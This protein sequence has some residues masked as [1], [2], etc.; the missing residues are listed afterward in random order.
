[1]SII[2]PNI[3]NG[4]RASRMCFRQI[5]ILY[6]CVSSLNALSMPVFFSEIHYDNLGSDVGEGFEVTGA[7]GTNLDGWSVALVNGSNGETYRNITLSG[8]IDNESNNA[9]A[10]GFLLG[11]IQNSV[12]GLALFNSF[13][14]L[15][16]FISYEGV[17]SNG[18]GASDDVGV[19]ENGRTLV[20]TSLQLFGTGSE[21]DDFSWGS[22]IANSFGSLNEGLVL[23]WGQ[24][25]AA[26]SEPYSLGLMC[27]GL[28]LLFVRR[29]S[30]SGR[31]V[32]GGDHNSGA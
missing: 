26:V 3:E 21:Y 16:Q 31:P 20:G 9:G 29:M 4:L 32:L 17:V 5:L 14:E 25:I 27:L 28:L 22:G 11:P 12:E 6:C 7:A 19:S 10:L 2:K 18:L 23:E 8:V 1:M 15:V 30:S 24:K 13:D